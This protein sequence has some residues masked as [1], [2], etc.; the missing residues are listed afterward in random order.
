MRLV[1]RGSQEPLAAD[2]EVDRSN[3]GRPEWLSMPTV[4]LRMGWQWRLTRSVR[5]FPVAAIR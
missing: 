4:D 2:P 3:A 5:I 1:W